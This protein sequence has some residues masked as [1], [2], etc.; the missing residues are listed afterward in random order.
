MALTDEKRK[1][2]NRNFW[3]IFT[4]G[5]GS[6]IALFTLIAIGWIGYIP[7]LD[8]LQNPINKSATEIYSSDMKL[9]GKFYQGTD[10]RI[11][12]NYNEIS[13]NVIDALI[14]TEDV[15]FF[16]HSGI[17][18][19]SLARATTGLLTGQQAGGGSTITQQLAKQ[20]YSPRAK[21][22]ITRIF[23]KPIE[24]VIA[25]K[26]EKLYA[27][28][29]IITMYLNQFDF[30]YNAVGIKSAAKIYF[31]TTADQLNIEQAA[32][33]VGMCK[34]PTYYNPLRYSE[35]SKQRRN[36][37]LQQMEKYDYITPQALDSLTKL[38]ITLHFKR[39]D[40]KEGLAT[41]FRQYLRKT[42]T[43]PKPQKRN[44]ADWQ[45]QQYKDDLWAWENDP[46]YGFFEKNKKADGTTYNLYTDGLKIYTT[47]DSR[48]QKYAEEAVNEHMM[49]LQKAFFREKK[50]RK[51]APFS[52]NIS[53]KQI[54]NILNNATKQTERYRKL[55]KNGAT[56]EQIDKSFRT[57]TEME[58][59][60]YKGW[61]DTIMT[62]ID[63]IRYHKHFLR[64]GLMSIDPRNGHVK[65]YVGG[66]NYK[67]FQYD[68]VTQG[69]R[70]VGSVIKPYLYT[71]AMEEGLTPCDKM[72]NEAIT[73]G[74]WTP[75]N[76]SNAR[77]GEEVT[78]RW[79]LANSN[80]YIT[81]RL[82]NLFTPDALVSMMRSFGIKGH[83][84]PVVSLALGAA[85]ISVAEMTEAYTAYPSKGIR[86]EAQYVTSIEDNNGN[87]IADFTP[88]VHE[89]FSESTAYKMLNML[90]AVI[91]EGTGRRVRYRYGLKMAAGGKTGTSQNNSDGWFMGFTPKL[92]SGVWVGGEERSIHF[93]YMT[94]G[95]GA[96][97]ALPIWS[98]YM[99]KILQDTQLE[100]KENDTFSIP[101]QYQY[102]L[103][104]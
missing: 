49:F 16:K 35:R 66:T 26:I 17:D 43:A 8:Q 76:S 28:E 20:L 99:K 79:G 22:K 69:R 11:P 89:I 2:F 57:K 14:A 54:E 95:Q 36:T 24:W 56:K 30:L 90:Q 47:I 55:K 75:K 92:V 19:R 44:Y 12:I 51:Y 67:A 65:A 82:M 98:I 9:I 100:Y 93:D 63:S 59:F 27:K 32:T 46:L 42:L 102:N 58:I 97:M 18:V 91:N 72:L 74:N 80:N 94:Y 48:M 33:L 101:A 71:L 5:I 31:G 103:C 29:E 88:K 23:Q 40:H 10:N 83:L 77:L 62:P 1:K 39:D 45:E 68:M 38:P 41:Y 15:R 85:E 37:V 7:N 86:T 3:K 34:N 53:Q 78:L 87:I 60:S 61:I 21:N 6:I 81:A 4:L 84:D 70:Q 73:I 13:P 25:I 50:G 104:E 64:S 96:A 52:R